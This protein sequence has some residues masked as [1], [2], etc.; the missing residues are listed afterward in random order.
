MKRVASFTGDAVDIRLDQH[1]NKKFR[2][3]YGLQVKSQLTY[4]Q[5]AIELGS[6]IMHAAACAG[7][8]D[9]SE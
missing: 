1:K 2:V 9:N 6:C 5:A 7:H 4:E 8:L 3:I